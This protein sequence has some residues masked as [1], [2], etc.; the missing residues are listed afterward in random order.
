MDSIFDSRF[1][2]DSRQLRRHKEISILTVKE[3]EEREGEK[4]RTGE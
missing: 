1:K 3:E 2:I 4:G